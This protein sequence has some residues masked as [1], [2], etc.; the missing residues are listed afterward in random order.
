MSNS[1]SP[2]IVALDFPDKAAALNLVEKLDPSRCR[3][4]V[5]KEM[6]TRL[7]PDFVEGL[8]GKGFDVFLDLKF[9]DIP[10]TVAAACSAACDPGVWMMNVHASGGRRMMEAA[11]EAIEKSSQS[12]LLM[13]VT[14]LTSLS[15]EDIKEVG[16][17]GTP[18]ENVMR[19]ATLASQS[20][21]DGV[22][23]SP[24]EVTALRESL[25][26]DFALVTP[27]IRPAGSAADDQRRTLTPAEAIAA[28][29]SY[30]VIGRQITQADNPMSVLLTIESEIAF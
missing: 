24:K 4:K 13:A 17:M 8:A 7:G 11:R 22:V 3:L 18:A 29:S 27:G 30:L 1:D 26:N 28:G 14:I 2:I 12:T 10:N 20:G 19:L 6:F 15:E 21:M 23:C 25:G 9:H 16:Y 5:G